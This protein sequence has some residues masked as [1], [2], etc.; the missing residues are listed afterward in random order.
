MKQIKTN[1][2]GPHKLHGSINNLFD[3]PISDCEGIYFWTVKTPF[4]NLIH[5]IGET[6]QSFKKRF[7]DHL[8]QTLGGY[9]HI[10][11]PKLLKAGKEAIIWN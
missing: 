10:W 9:Y 11:D 4:G 8:I 7:K 1:L 5:Y 2:I 3:S 6:G